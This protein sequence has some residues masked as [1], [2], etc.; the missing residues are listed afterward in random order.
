[1]CCLNLSVSVMHRVNFRI[2]NRTTKHTLYHYNPT[3]RPWFFSLLRSRPKITFDSSLRI[4]MDTKRA[5][6]AAIINTA[7]REYSVNFSIQAAKNRKP[8]I[9]K[10]QYFERMKYSGTNTAEAPCFFADAILRWERSSISRYLVT[11]PSE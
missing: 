2:A 4:I 9:A 5:G 3:I 6:I 10:I 8:I 1:M 7:G 11:S